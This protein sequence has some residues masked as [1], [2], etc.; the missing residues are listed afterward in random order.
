MQ[1]LRSDGAGTWETY[2]RLA[3]FIV[4]KINRSQAASY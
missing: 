3:E 2:E 4:R 1:R